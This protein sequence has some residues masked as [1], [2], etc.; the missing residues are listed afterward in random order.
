MDVTFLTVCPRTTIYEAS[1][2]DFRIILARDATSLVYDLGIQE[3]KNIGVS[4][5]D[6]DECISW[7]KGPYLEDPRR[8]TK[9]RGKSTN[10]T[11]CKRLEEETH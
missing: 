1:E 4:V 2:R 11:A 5:M 3:L 6:T 10:P 8:T 7:L 9:I